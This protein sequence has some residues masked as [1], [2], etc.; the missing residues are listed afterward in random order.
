MNFLEFR[1]K[2]FDLAC[3]SIDQVYA[4]QP[5]FDRNN[6]GRWIDKGMLIRLKQGYFTF[7]E[8]KEKPD[9]AFYFANRI[10]R[11]SY[12]SLHTALSFYGLIPEAVIQITNVTPLKTASFKNTFAQYNYKSVKSELMFGYVLK[13]MPDGRV[14]HF[15]SPEKALLDLLYL[16][17]EYNTQRQ[18]VDLRLD[19]D[20][21]YEELNVQLLHEYRQSFKNKALDRRIQLLLSNYGL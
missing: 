18:M 15:A 7:P 16:Y 14:I 11:P 1:S 8:Y 17:P 6:L 2:M 21:L 9:Y 20:F 13:P 12:I 19:E 4:W 10:Y 5:G 3:F